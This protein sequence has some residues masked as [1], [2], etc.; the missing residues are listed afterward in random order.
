M[1][2]YILLDRSGSMSNLWDEAIGS[3]N[4][5]VET[6]KNSDK[7]H[8]AVFDS[9]SHDVIRDVKA[10]EWTIVCP[11]EVSPRA[12]TPLYDSCGKIMTQAESD[13]V[14][15]T[16]VVVMTDG[17]ENCSKEYTQEA[18]KARV[19]QFED[20]QWEV[21]FLGANFD[22]VESVS[23]S[24]GVMSSKTMNISAGNMRSAMDTLTGYTTAYSASGATINFSAEDKI[25]A[26]LNV[27]SGTPK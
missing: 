21:I 8:L 12:S 23:S 14:K 24:V 10:K 1:N 13:N 7:V 11:T 9:I 5:Y 27:K 18:I 15:K 22:A 20:K 26:T 2:V 4:G 17:Y 6:L 3:I 16:V 19:K 25:K